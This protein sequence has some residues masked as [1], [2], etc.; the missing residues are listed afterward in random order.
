MNLDS[1][2]TDVKANVFLVHREIT[3]SRWVNESLLAWDHVLTTHDV[4]RLTRRPPW[5][6]CGMA[7]LRRFPK[8]HR[9]H[10][11]KIGWLKSDVFD[12]MSRGSRNVSDVGPTEP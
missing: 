4:A 5:L 1:V 11:L 8:K 3:I 6:L 12:W 9:F 7:L 2:R 10:G